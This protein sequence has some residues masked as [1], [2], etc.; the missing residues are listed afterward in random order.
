[1]IVGVGIDLCDVGRFEQLAARHGRR[2]LERI[3][4]PL[5]RQACRGRPLEHLAARFAVKE[6]FAKAVRAARVPWREVWIATPPGRPPVLALGG[7]ARRMAER[8]GARRW[9]VSLAHDAGLAAAV[10]LLEGDEVAEDEALD[11]ARATA[12][13]RRRGAGAVRDRRPGAD[14]ERGARRGRAAP[15]AGAQPA[16]RTAGPGTPRGPRLRTGQQRR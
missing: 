8:R 12:A 10:V 14:G 4:T 2:F 11:D 6:A 5:E 15:A 16:A 1:V 9:L 7:T 3:F 13:L